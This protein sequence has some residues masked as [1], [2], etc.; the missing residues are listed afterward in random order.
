MREGTGKPLGRALRVEGLVDLLFPIDHLAA[1]LVGGLGGGI[2]HGGLDQPEMALTLLVAKIL[3]RRVG[4]LARS[5]RGGDGPGHGAAHVA[6]EPLPGL[7]RDLRA[8]LQIEH[9][10]RRLG[11]ADQRKGL[12]QP[13]RFVPVRLGGDRVADDVEG[14]RF[15]M[16]QPGADVAGLFEPQ[17]EAPRVM[18]DRLGVAQAEYQ[19]L[20]P[21]V[22]VVP[23]GLAELVVG[24][25]RDHGFELLAEAHRGPEIELHRGGLVGMARVGGRRHSAGDA[26]PN[27][28]P[29]GLRQVADPPAHPLGKPRK[30]LVAGE[31]VGR[32]LFLH[33]ERPEDQLEQGAQR[34]QIGQTR[35]DLGRNQAGAVLEPRSRLVD[36]QLAANR[37]PGHLLG[38]LLGPGLFARPLGHGREPEP[39]LFARHG[40]RQPGLVPGPMPPVGQRTDLAQA[41][42]A[43]VEIEGGGLGKLERLE[44]APRGPVPVVRI[45]VDRVGH[46]GDRRGWGR[47]RRLLRR[48]LCAHRS[49]G[50]FCSLLRGCGLGWGGFLR[51]ILGGLRVLG[52][53]RVELLEAIHELLGDLPVILSEGLSRALVVLNA[54]RAGVCV[55]PIGREIGRA[56]V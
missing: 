2:V 18:L 29:I 50:P 40:R 54:L 51:Q 7:L 45:E 26:I 1:H 15:R 32:I 34:K 39:R 42:H 35:H 4:E 30:Q 10:G 28:L 41:P 9:H 6:V 12:D 37:P 16:G 55:D 43:V 31:M 5:G 22:A 44:L 20:R 52:L 33:L 11:G 27:P 53:A 47:S 21:A 14:G 25:G 36:R 23:I 19:L 3:D 48:G 8:D 17:L 46:V 38:H 49:A 13:G 56:H 24:P